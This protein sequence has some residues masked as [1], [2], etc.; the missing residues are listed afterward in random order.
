MF[1][2]RFF[3]RPR[4]G[5]P[6]RGAGGGSSAG[7]TL[8]EALVAL[9][10]TAVCLGAIG[11]LMATNIRASR[12]IDERVALVSILRKVELALPERKDLL[13]ANL[14]GEMAGH[15]WALTSAPF[16]DPS[17]P[18]SVKPPPSWMPQAVVL[19]VRSPSG[20]L[21]EVETLRLTPRPSQ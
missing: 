14:A 13:D 12:Q 19:K 21:V 11:T 1:R 17:P 3:E 10:V 2:R 7:F 8:I 6:R 4:P 20:S 16:P 15:Q 9:A 18:P 5:W